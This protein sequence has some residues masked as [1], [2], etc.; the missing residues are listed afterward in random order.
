MFLEAV[1]M[2]FPKAFNSNPHDLLI[3]NMHAYG[4]PKTSLV[5]FYS[6]LKKKTKG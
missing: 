3:A 4:F 1:L 2:D 6:Y 5:F